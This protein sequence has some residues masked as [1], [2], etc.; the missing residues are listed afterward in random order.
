M[1]YENCWLSAARTVL[2]WGLGL[3]PGRGS[4]L[5]GGGGREG[6]RSAKIPGTDT[7][8]RLLGREGGRVAENPKFLGPRSKDAEGGRGQNRQNFWD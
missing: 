8:A 4:R 1:H 7:G 3:T 6:S 2:E 5:L